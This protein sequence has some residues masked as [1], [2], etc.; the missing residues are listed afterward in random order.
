[1]IRQAQTQ[2][3]PRLLRVRWSRHAWRPRIIITPAARRSAVSL[4]VQ[5]GDDAAPANLPLPPQFDIP[6]EPGTMFVFR[7]DGV[8]VFRPNVS[9]GWAGEDQNETPSRNGAAA[10]HSIFQTMRS[11][12]W[13][14]RRKPFNVQPMKKPSLH[15]SRRGFTLIELLVVIAIIG[16]LA[17]LLLPAL[18]KAIQKGK[19]TT[20]RTE[21]NGIIAAITAYEQTYSRFPASTEAANSLT[22]NCPDFTFG[23]FN[24][25]QTPPN[26]LNDKRGNQLA[27]VTNTGNNN[28][29]QNSNA[30]IMGILLDMTN[31]AN[32]LATVNIN[33]VKNPQRTVFLN[34]KF[35]GDATSPG[36]G[37]DGVYRDPWG[38]PY[39]ITL[40]MNYDNK[41]RDAFY[42]QQKVSQQ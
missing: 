30:E 2:K 24:L 21:M 6:L 18:S 31:Y 26:Y 35:S 25:A 37:T 13:V 4:P 29:Y 1:M 8:L 27:H 9:A 34:P 17:G 40:D 28:N 15:S 16:I 7:R 41:C 5:I 36:V 42:R 33:H 32:G 19:I 12:P 14:S 23:T 10:S 22:A 11:I 20:A 39:I 3:L 38:T